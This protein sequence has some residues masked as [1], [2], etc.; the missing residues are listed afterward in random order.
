MNAMKHEI[1]GLLGAATVAAMMTVL[2]VLAGDEK[3]PVK[4]EGEARNAAADAT[5]TPA[6][7][8]N[9]EP[10]TLTYEKSV[11]ARDRYLFMGDEMTQ[12][13][14][15]VRAVATGLLAMKPEMN[16]RF[17][18]GG[19]DDATT[20]SALTW[21]DDLLEI[22]RPTVVFICFGLNDGQVK[23]GDSA[24][25]LVKAYEQNLTGLVKKAQEHKGVRLVVVMSPP[26]IQAGLTDPIDPADYN[27]T[28]FEMSKVSKRVAAAT[29]SAFVDTF[30][31]TRRTYLGQMQA[32]GDPLTYAGRLPTEMAHV[33][34][35]SFIFKMMGVPASELEAT[36]WSPIRPRE[37]KRIRGA[38]ALPLKAPDVETAQASRDLYVTI[39]K[40]DET[41]FRYWRLAGKNPSSPSRASLTARLEDDWGGVR[42]AVAY[43]K[44]I[45]HS[46]RKAGGSE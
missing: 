29:G 2:P 31:V 46:K 36:G 20:E 22:S 40:F 35:A 1:V 28:L 26:A 7:P 27:A 15:Y 44:R 32:G 21:A 3:T 18:N 38:L 34:L 5:P 43:V 30:D 11:Q 42:E 24:Q 23:V 17:Y 41:F 45:D 37:M 14:F 16:L 25:P 10:I 19:K 4:A 8:A 33:I 9:A 13:M 39:T 6:P 12:Q